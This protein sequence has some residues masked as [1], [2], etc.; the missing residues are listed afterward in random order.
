MNQEYIEIDLL[1]L[2][3]A[4]L[5]RWWLI[6]ILVAVAGSI[7]AYRTVK[8]VVPVYQA[9]ATLFIGKESASLSSLSLDDLYIGGQLISD[10][11]QLITTR[12]VTQTVIDELGLNAK[13][14]D[15]TGN[16]GISDITDSRFMYVAYTDPIPERAQLIVNK[17]SQVLV[18][19]A[20]TVVGVKNI[21][22]VDSALTPENPIGPSLKKNVVIA[23]FIGGV[24]ALGLIFLEIF[25][26]NT[27]KN[28]SEIEKLIQVPVLGTIPKF[29]G[30]PRIR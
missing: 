30:E 15:L 29:K 9:R 22:I 14:K 10:Y 16:I 7:S 2:A 3:K 28:E 24:L 1:E 20:G 5:R 23:A 26:Q 4:V 11:K 21:Q 6:V 8:Y 25:M 17:L 12:A 13:P 18:E 27:V 19:K